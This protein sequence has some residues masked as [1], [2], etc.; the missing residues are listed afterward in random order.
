MH[1]YLILAH[2]NYHQLQQLVTS[3]DDERNDIYIH[4][5]KKSD[6][7]NLHLRTSYSNLYFA[8]KEDVRWGG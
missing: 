3:L 6:T 8:E 7:T 1:A 4:I 2:T 5:D